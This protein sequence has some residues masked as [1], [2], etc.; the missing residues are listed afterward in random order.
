MLTV[1]VRSHDYGKDAPEA[2]FSRI[3]KD[4]YQAVM[5]AYQKAI[6]GVSSYDD[7]T[8]EMVAQTTAALRENKL[9]INT[10]GVY[11]ELGM[12]DEAERSKA[13]AQFLTGLKVAK[14]TGVANVATE[15]TPFHKQP[16]TAPEDALKSLYRSLEEILPTAEEY[17]LKVC[18]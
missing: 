5:L 7:V 14:E 6:A 18:V 8:P 12:V 15:T 1:G 13:V 10:L 11:M 2:L 16:D 4:G 17:R 3:A 9:A